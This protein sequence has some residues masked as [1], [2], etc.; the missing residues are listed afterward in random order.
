MK[1]ANTPAEP[2][3]FTHSVVMLY[4]LY[5]GAYIGPTTVR[6][7]WGYL[8]DVPTEALRAAF[9]LAIRA[10]PD[11]CPSAAQ[12]RAHAEAVAKTLDGPKP[13]MTRLA[14]PEPEPV[15][16]EDNPFFETLERFKRGDLPRQDEA[17]A[18]I[19]ALAGCEVTGGDK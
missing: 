14:L 15:L 1:N 10:S 5:P 3:W 13:D 11:R 7:W 9:R 19:N 6:S 17:K 2:A 8:R 18:A 4:D 16:P 12:V